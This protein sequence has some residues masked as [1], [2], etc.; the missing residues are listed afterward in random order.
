MTSGATLGLTFATTTSIP[1]QLGKW[2]AL[3]EA[4]AKR[5]DPSPY[6]T[7]EEPR[8]WSCLPITLQLL[9]GGALRILFSVPNKDI[10]HA[11]R[12][13][14]EVDTV[15]GVI[16]WTP[17]PRFAVETF[18]M[19]ADVLPIADCAW[20]LAEIVLTL[21][22]T[23]RSIGAR[24]PG[25]LH[26][27]FLHYFGTQEHRGCMK[28]PGWD[29]DNGPLPNRRELSEPQFASILQVS[30]QYRAKF[31]SDAAPCRL[32]WRYFHHGHRLDGLK[33]VRTLAVPELTAPPLPPDPPPPPQPPPL[34]PDP[35]PPAQSL[36]KLRVQELDAQEARANVISQEELERR[37]ADK[38]D[39]NRPIQVL[40][41]DPHAPPVAM[42][43]MAF[44]CASVED[45][46]VMVAKL[47]AVCSSSKVGPGQVKPYELQV[48]DASRRT[49]PAR[50]LMYVHRLIADDV[51]RV[52]DWAQPHP[53][54][55]EW[56]DSRVLMKVP[57]PDWNEGGVAAPLAHSVHLAALLH[58]WFERCTKAS[59]KRCRKFLQIVSDTDAADLTLTEEQQHILLELSEEYLILLHN[60]WWKE[61]KDGAAAASA[62][63][64]PAAVPKRHESP[65]NVETT[66]FPKLDASPAGDA[67]SGRTTYLPSMFAITTPA[68]RPIDL[69]QLES[70][71]Y[72]SPSRKHTI[73][74]SGQKAALGWAVYTGTPKRISAW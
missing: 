48:L 66:D 46:P 7:S 1:V 25:T 18:G 64:T 69:K 55:S 10:F 15:R 22:D 14:M 21:F 52:P 41:R 67:P 12:P 32:S 16:A 36:L 53:T 50:V 4:F 60:E 73:W 31:G 11:M 44:M 6:A 35:L 65:T 13:W 28:R 39:T 3:H 70:V 33:Y 56:S 19:G 34:P 58:A 49:L 63:V 30:D 24:D 47:M 74:C 68:M 54:K 29:D 8:L 5:S 72:L 45:V 59:S 27:C 26:D 17:M 61:P 51:R 20:Y 42:V 2:V 38:R 62:V 37:L 9:E 43:S 40:Q 57:I 23:F 71:A